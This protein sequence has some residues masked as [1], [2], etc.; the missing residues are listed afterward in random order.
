MPLHTG[1]ESRI[2]LG[3]G[4]DSGDSL[5]IMGGMARTTCTGP[6]E[7]FPRAVRGHGK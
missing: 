1:Q 6:A 4:F 3:F 2:E 7:D 5:G